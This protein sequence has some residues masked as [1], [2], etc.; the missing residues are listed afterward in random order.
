LVANELFDLTIDVDC[1]VAWQRRL[2]H[3]VGIDLLDQ[4][5]LLNRRYFHESWRE[6]LLQRRLVWLLLVVVVVVG[7]LIVIG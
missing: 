6:V 2:E 7:E 5:R 1:G 3:K 4:L